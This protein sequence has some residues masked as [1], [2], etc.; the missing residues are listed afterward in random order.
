MHVVKLSLAATTAGCPVRA[1]A[2]NPRGKGGPH[3]LHGS[4]WISIGVDF[5]SNTTQ[6]DS[7]DGQCLT[8]VIL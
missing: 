6:K 3:S 1:F 5:Y 7:Q 4:G 8:S 2:S